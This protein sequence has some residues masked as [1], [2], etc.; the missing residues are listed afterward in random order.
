MKLDGYYMLCEVVGIRDLK[1]DSTAF[2]SA[3][4]RRHIWGLPVEVPYVPKRRR[5]GF[6]VYA[7]M[8]G[9]Y[10]YSVLYIVARFAGNVV[11]N[12]S[13]EWG[14]VPEIAVALWIFRSRIRL[15][16]NFMKLVYLDKKD[17]IA[18][19]LTPRRL[20]LAGASV[21]AVCAL[22]LRREA[23]SGRFLLE[24]EHAVTIRA[25]IPGVLTQIDAQ[26]GQ[27]VTAGE[28]IATVQNLP[29]NSDHQRA[30][31]QLAVAK[32][33]TKEASL[34]YLDYGAAREHQEGLATQVQQLE[35]MQKAMSLQSPISGTVLTPRAVDLLGSYV[36][37]GGEIA[38]V[39][40][41]TSL[42]ARIYISEYEMRKIRLQG[43]GRLQVDGF[44]RRWS[45]SVQ[46]IGTDPK[47][48]EE[49]LGPKAELQGTTPPHF[50]LVDL[51]VANSDSHLKPGM[52]GT[53][54]IYGQ[55]RSLW[56]LALE[57]TMN[58]FGRKLW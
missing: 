52:T 16:V 24:P 43:P 37:A 22:P 19:W 46:A 1:E 40:D 20:L 4:M 17:R 15:L 38:E 42:R 47:E 41:L 9:I 48:M 50:Y 56:G 2:V 23:V 10:C 12:F 13:P 55:R 53:A 11:R 57:G 49:G 39:A 35:R 34:H 30:W 25:L 14:F 33:Q 18:E 44:A 6:A 8:S 26:E 7:V 32:V 5:L 58:F 21:A 29:L 45:A 28:T 31:T 51:I 27:P 36:L 54:R 3:W